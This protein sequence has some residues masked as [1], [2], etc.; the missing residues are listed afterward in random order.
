MVLTS[1]LRK[2]KEDRA[3]S[4]VGQRAE[5]GGVSRFWMVGKTSWRYPN[6]G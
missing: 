3:G 6:S 4:G 1:A 2:D 5:G